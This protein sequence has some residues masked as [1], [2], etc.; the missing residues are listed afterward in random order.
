MIGRLINANQTHHRTEEAYDAAGALY[1]ILAVILMYGCSVLLMI[2]S[3]V[4]KS[5]QDTTVVTYTKGME[6]RKKM[7]LKQDK[8]RTKLQMHKKKVHRILGPDRA[9][10]LEVSKYPEAR[11]PSLMSPTEDVFCWEDR[12]WEDRRPS[13]SSLAT[14][15]VCSDDLRSVD[16]PYFMT[17]QWNGYEEN[18]FLSA[19]N[20]PTVPQNEQSCF[21]ILNTRGIQNNQH[22]NVLEMPEC[23][24]NYKE[25]HDSI[26]VDK[27]ETSQCGLT[28]FAYDIPEVRI[29]ACE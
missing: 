19:P 14:T 18:G 1:Y 21:P 9:E 20:S 29:H 5:S 16:L 11:S 15:I 10:V 3:F 13:G 2:G 22:Q 8:F 24:E 7:Q 6:S 4:K 26:N 28:A 27:K 17:S 12:E 25:T 23:K